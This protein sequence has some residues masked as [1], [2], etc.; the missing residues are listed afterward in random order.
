MKAYFD[1]GKIRIEINGVEHAIDGATCDTLVNQLLTARHLEMAGQHQTG[2]YGCIDCGEER[3]P[4]MV[5]GRPT[6]PECGSQ[7]LTSGPV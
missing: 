7:K 5:A 3:E 6:C 2:V 1:N 4:R